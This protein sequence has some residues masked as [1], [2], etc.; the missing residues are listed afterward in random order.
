[1]RNPVTQRITLRTVLGIGPIV[2]RL[3]LFIGL[4]NICCGP[5]LLRWLSGIKHKLL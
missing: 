5:C 4:R 3:A 1:M 2:G